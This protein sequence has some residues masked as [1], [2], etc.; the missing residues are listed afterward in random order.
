MAADIIDEVIIDGVE[1]WKVRCNKLQN[2]VFFPKLEHPTSGD[3]PSICF[4]CDYLFNQLS[5]GDNITVRCPTDNKFQNRVYG[6]DTSI[7]DPVTGKVTF[8]CNQS[9]VGVK[10]SV[11]I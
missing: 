4:N 7:I 5:S 6:I 9:H 3:V 10:S 2:I 8:T 1:Y 11:L